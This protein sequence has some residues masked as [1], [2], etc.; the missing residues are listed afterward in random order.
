MNFE[1]A[2]NLALGLW[3]LIVIALL[4]L[5]GWMAKGEKA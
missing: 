4:F 3:V 5:C 1:T 2:M